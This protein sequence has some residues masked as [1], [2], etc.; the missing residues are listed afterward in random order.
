M[1]KENKILIVD[2]DNIRLDRFIRRHYPYTFQGLL[3]KAIRKQLITVDNKKALANQRLKPKQ[4]VNICQTLIDQLVSKDL[5]Q[6]V[7]STKVDQRYIDL[8]KEAIIHKDDELIILNKPSGI[9]VQG[10]SKI[11]ISIDDI[12]EYLKF[13]YQIKPKLVH[14]LDKDTSGLLMIARTAA[15][16]NQL[17]NSFQQR[18]INKTYLAIVYNRPA[19]ESGIISNYLSKTQ[20]S[21]NLEQMAISDN[22][23]AKLAITRYSLI[24]Y[25]LAKNISILRLQPVTGRTHQLRVHCQG[26]NTPILGDKK[27]NQREFKDKLNY[28][29]LHA[30]QLSGDILGRSIKFTAPL[31]DHFDKLINKLNLK[32]QLI[33]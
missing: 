24:D 6:R 23:Q 25:S 26:L 33:K 22:N 1:S 27:Y 14:R 30:Y 16:A 3:E 13:D 28:L 2:E 4:Q 5:P 20:I 21:N 12:L 11:K 7:N 32:I 18:Q 29:F 8:I 9:A 17:I 31:P 15:V 19:N 10:G